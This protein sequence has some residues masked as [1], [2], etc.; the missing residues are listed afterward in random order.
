MRLTPRFDDAL[1]LATRHHGTQVRKGTG[2]P[3]VSHLLAVTA[4]VLEAGGDESEAIGALLHDAVEDGGGPEMLA[5]IRAEFGDDVA[6]IVEENSDS[7]EQPK[8]PWRE[9]KERYLAAIPSKSAPAVL[10]SIADKL[11]N[12]RSILLDYRTVGEL[13]LVALQARRERAGP[14]VL[15]RTAPGLRGTRGPQ[16]G[17]EGA[18]GRAGTHARRARAARVRNRRWRA[19]RLTWRSMTR[20]IYAGSW[21]LARRATRRR[22]ATGGASS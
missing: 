12:A 5:S 4:L 16:P 11:H 1:L 8:P 3:Y 20:S 6:A 15:P 2:V 17:C 13:A 10:V 22:C 14:L 9:R 18:R 21:P 19:T 7:D